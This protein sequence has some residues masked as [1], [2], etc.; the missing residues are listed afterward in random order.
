MP[1]PILFYY[2]TEGQMKAVWMDSKDLYKAKYFVRITKDLNLSI[3][4][5]ADKAA[6]DTVVEAYKNFKP[7]L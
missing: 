4:P 1:E 2:Y 3:V 6:I 5:L 7:T